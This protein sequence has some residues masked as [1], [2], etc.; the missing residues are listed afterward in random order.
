MKFRAYVWSSSYGAAGNGA[1]P[2][3]AMREALRAYRA[4][5]ARG[6]P[7]WFTVLEKPS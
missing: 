2:F 5:M 4:V 1:T 6:R 3:G 7:R